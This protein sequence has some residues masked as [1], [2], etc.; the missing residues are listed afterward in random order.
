[1][2]LRR[3]VLRAELLDPRAG[4]EPVAAKLEVRWDPLTGHSSRIVS[5]PKALIPPVAVDLAQVAKDNEPTCPFCAA[6]IDQHTPK[7][8]ADIWSD[9]RI[10]RGEA[11]LFPNLLA[12]GKHSSVAVY[13]PDRHFF[14]IDEMT[15]RLMVDNLAV[16]VEFARAVMRYD[17]E[18]RWSSINANHMAPSGSSVFHPHT[19]GSVD[20]LPTTMQRAL[21]EGPPDRFARYLKLEKAAGER[22]LGGSG[23]VHWLASF[24]PLGPGELRALIPRVTSTIEFDD[25]LIEELGKGL[26]T[27]LNLYAE[28]GYQSF[29]LA[30]YG[31]PP[32]TEAYALNLR[33][34]CRSNPAPLYRS[35]ATYLERLH[36]EAAVDINPEALAERAR[37]RFDG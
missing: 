8:P 19:Q 4:F 17:P 11:V 34:L 36:W 15:A 20:P 1:M 32:E 12:Y 28:L 25:S 27:A 13:S 10:R 21:C 14:P 18:A 30:I 3:E 9:G 29:N 6:R 35:D 33:I 22:Y 7:L 23:E 26:A 2:E 31:A 5:S 24:A 16:Q 37:G